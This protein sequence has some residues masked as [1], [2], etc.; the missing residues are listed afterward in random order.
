MTDLFH[1]F[2]QDLV[3]DQ[4]GALACARETIGTRQSVLRRLCTNENDYLWHR[5]YGAGLPARIGTPLREAELQRL[6]L[7]QLAMEARIDQDAPISVRIVASPPGGA[8]CTITYTERGEA[9]QDSFS[10]NQD[11]TV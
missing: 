4:D 9:G 6:I 11:G 1:Y 5:S 8:A 3:C 10:F 2:G 7:A